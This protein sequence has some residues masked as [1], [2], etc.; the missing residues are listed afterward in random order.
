MVGCN[1]P[2]CFYQESGRCVKDN[3][4][5]Q[6]EVKDGHDTI[7]RCLS[8]RHRDGVEYVWCISCDGKTPKDEMKG[9]LCP[10]CRETMR[11]LRK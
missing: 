6:F 4:I 3:T 1:S 9:G 7:L 8:Y 10:Y 2:D 5:V 11:F